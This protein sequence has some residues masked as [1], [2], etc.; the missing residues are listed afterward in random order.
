MQLDL[1]TDQQQVVQDYRD[2]LVPAQQAQRN[3]AALMRRIEAGD[4][5]ELP[6]PE[7][8]PQPERSR[9]P[10]AWIAA[11]LVLLATGATAAYVA[12][13]FG[14][15]PAVI[16]ARP[17]ERNPSEVAQYTRSSETG[18]ARPVAGP[19]AGRR[20]TQWPR[21]RAEAVIESAQGFAQSFTS[22]VAGVSVPGSGR[23]LKVDSSQTHVSRKHSKSSIEAEARLIGGARMALRD[24]RGQLALRL[25]DRH[26]R[27][28]AKGVMTPERRALRVAAL[29][30]L[31][32][33]GAAKR[34]ARA[35]L[36]DFRGSP[37][38]AN[39]EKHC[40]GSVIGSAP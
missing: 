8:E 9:H 32:Q 5:V 3:W 15:E 11:A 29:C 38:S 39:V 7:A 13:S 16:A 4:T 30:M 26:A 21:A 19:V 37:L 20:L 28:H 40:E 31:G 25:L 14:S 36:R 10:L 35:F 22:S 23:N 27:Q 2:T 34:E 12:S 24:E 33:T 17:V 6:E 1:D 18:R